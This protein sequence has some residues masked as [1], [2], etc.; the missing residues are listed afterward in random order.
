VSYKEAQWTE[1]EE[2]SGRGRRI[3]KEKKR[4]GGV[5]RGGS[6]VV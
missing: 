6:Q 3:G 4:Y 1:L 5:D 2:A